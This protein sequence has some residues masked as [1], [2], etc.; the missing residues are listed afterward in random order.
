MRRSTSRAKHL[1]LYEINKADI[2]AAKLLDTP[3]V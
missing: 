3:E 1:D 2:A